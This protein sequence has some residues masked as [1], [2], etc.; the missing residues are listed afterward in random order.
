MAKKNGFVDSSA[1]S[2][3]SS[4]NNKS[5]S[6]AEPLNLQPG[7]ANDVFRTQNES[8]GKEQSKNPSR[9]KQQKGSHIPKDAE[10]GYYWRKYGQKQVK[11]SEYP[12]SYFK[13]TNVNCKVKKKVERSHDGDITEIVYNGGDHNHP[14][15]Q[16]V[17]RFSDEL[18][19]NEGNCVKSEGGVAFSKDVTFCSDWRND[20]VD[21]AFSTLV[22]SD[23][24]TSL[25]KGGVLFEG[26]EL[27]STICSQEADD[28][29]KSSPDSI[30]FNG[31]EEN[32]DCEPK[33]RCILL[34]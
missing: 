23:Y 31:D 32:G 28:N 9:E 12:R 20:G 26:Q 16:P 29:G 11:G 22:L 8:N 25:A 27:S 19:T 13:C 30:S 10:D 17:K 7:T 21:G 15:P 34:H 2:Y 24:P 33:K 5:W 1:M 18:D 4:G 6:E 14:K 3:Q